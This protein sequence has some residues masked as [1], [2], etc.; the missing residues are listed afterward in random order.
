MNHLLSDKHSLDRIIPP[1]YYLFRVTSDPLKISDIKSPAQKKSLQDTF[2]KIRSFLFFFHRKI[3]NIGICQVT[4]VKYLH[5]F[6]LYLSLSLSLNQSIIFLSED[7]QR[8]D[9][10]KVKCNST[11]SESPKVTQV[12]Q[13][14]IYRYHRL[15][16][17]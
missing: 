15:Y 14:H 16:M 2:G 3:F 4:V 6:F 8:N 17:E 12:L 7:I 13:D 10:E 11:T 1:V 9:R 5:H